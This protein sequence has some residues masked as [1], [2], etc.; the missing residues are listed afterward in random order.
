MDPHPAYLRPREVQTGVVGHLILLKKRWSKQ[1]TPASDGA[2]CSFECSL[3]KL[4]SQSG[5]LAFTVRTPQTRSASNCALFHHSN[6]PSNF[7]AEQCGSSLPK[8]H[9]GA[10]W[11]A[12][13]RA[14]ALPLENIS[15]QRE[16][17]R[18]Q[19]QGIPGSPGSS[20][21]RT[22]LFLTLTPFP[23]P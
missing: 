2:V 3:R 16:V 8:V 4:P 6:T 20:L 5:P 7:T 18:P 12:S 14:A 19:V 22:Q 9:G 17:I 21:K 13:G 11:T 15:G 10:P 23:A 1:V